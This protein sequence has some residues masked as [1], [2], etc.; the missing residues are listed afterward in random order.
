MSGRAAVS[1]ATRA[2]GCAVGGPRHTPSGGASQLRPFWPPAS[3]SSS[4]SIPSLLTPATRRFST[5]AHRHAR[6]QDHYAVFGLPRNASKA[7]IKARFY[8]LSKQHHP[9]A[10][11]GSG[12][13]DKFHTLNDAYAVLGDDGARAAYDASS[14][15]ASSRGVGS[16]GS[17]FHPHSPQSRR[18]SGPH[19]AWGGGR[20]P[21]PPS[22]AG[23]RKV[24]PDLGWGAGMGGTMP[25]YSAPHSAHGRW[26]RK[27]EKRR[28]GE[29]RLDEDVAGE[30]VG[31]RFVIVLLVL[32][33]VWSLGSTVAKAD[34]GEEEEEEEERG[35]DDETWPRRHAVDTPTT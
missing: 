10:A 13:A 14:S 18:S 28:Q 5:T 9:D 6:K 31:L 33:V 25:G 2:W 11:G 15:P 19:R 27:E 26:G 21:P 7:Q 12:S 30:S 32:I 4:S 3:S 35:D 22:W 1:T 24:A 34:G 8:E 29:S 23:R 16:E 20:A 17:S